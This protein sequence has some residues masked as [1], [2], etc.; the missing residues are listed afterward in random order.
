[1]SEKQVCVGAVTRPHG[2]RG[3]VCVEWYAD[4]PSFLDQEVRLEF[5]GGKSRLIRARQYRL[6]KG[7][8]LVSFDGIASRD[9]AEFLRGATIW[10]PRDRLP[11]LPDGEAYLDDLLGLRVELPDG[12]FAGVLD[13][14]EMPAG[15]M[16]W[17]L[18]DGESEVL[19]PAHKQFI[20][21]LGD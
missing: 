7:G 9:E 10:I 4:A 12:T 13:H 18:R 16:V 20:V 1:M 11:E 19:F 15:Q 14:I 5:P 8:L 2:V 21:S 3:D 17:A 6:H